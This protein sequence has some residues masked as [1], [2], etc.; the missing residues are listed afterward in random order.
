MFDTVLKFYKNKKIKERLQ[1]QD[2][3]DL[4]DIKLDSL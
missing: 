4:C 1:I 3:L 2:I